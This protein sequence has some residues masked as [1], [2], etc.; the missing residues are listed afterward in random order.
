MKEYNVNQFV[1]SSSATVYGMS[2]EMPL[3]E[4]MQTGGC[5]NPYG[6]TKWMIEQILQDVAFANKDMSIALLRY[7]NPVG[8]HESGLIGENPRGIP[9]NLMPYIT[10]VA[11]GK[12]KELSVFGND[13]PTKDGTGKRD[14]IHVV[15]LA[16]AHVSAC[17]YLPSNKGCQVFNIGTGNGYTVLDLINTF[18]KVNNIKIPFKITQRRPGDVAECYANCSKAE[19]VLNW[20]AELSL[21]DMV[22]DSW[23]WQTKNPEGY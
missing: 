21:D 16:K 9:N 6:W 7:F 8:A 20:K 23:N 4:T 10:Q 12:L 11:N 19:K 1:F 13:Y 15:D 5:T 14:F 22:K 18:E 2:T 17:E 3:L